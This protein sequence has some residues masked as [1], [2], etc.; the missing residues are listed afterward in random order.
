MITP[1]WMC[2]TDERGCGER[3]PG[4][5]YAEC[6]LAPYG[7]PLWKFLLDPPVPVPPGLD[8]TNKSQILQR[9]DASGKP[10]YDQ[11]TEQPIYDLYCMYGKSGYP[12]PSDVW[13]EGR[14]LGFSRRLNENLPLH[15]LTKAS[16]MFLAHPLAY[17]ENWREFDLPK[18]CEAHKSYHSLESFQ[19]RGIL[20][21]GHEGILA[22]V[23]GPCL[24]LHWDL[25]REA[26]ATEVMDTGLRKIYSRK[27]GSTIYTFEP[28]T[29]EVES[30][31]TPALFADLP[32]S[33][34][35]LIR[36]KNGAVNE[37][38]KVKIEKSYETAGEQG[39]LPCYESD[40]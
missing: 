24:S 8:L 29:G 12:Y 5:V 37:K 35:A 26:D 20:P 36:D 13:E 23:R 22:Q 31:R 30:V 19:K 10:I 1:R 4:G 17:V 21:I 9:V 11:F 33:G 6:A 14:R 2:E 16:R 39:A 28:Y 18:Q 34:L 38:A 25:L 32:I 40:R 27:V 3:T 15:L 7:E